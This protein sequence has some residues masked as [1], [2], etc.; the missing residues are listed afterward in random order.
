[1]KYFYLA[2]FMLAMLFVGCKD[3]SPPVEQTTFCTD[4]KPTVQSQVDS[5]LELV[6]TP[7]GMSLADIHILDSTGAQ[8][9]PADVLATI[10]S[11]AAENAVN[12]EFKTQVKAEAARQERPTN[13][14]PDV[15]KLLYSLLGA[16]LFLLSQ[17]LFRGR[18]LFANTD[19]DHIR[20]I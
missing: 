6:I 1:M 3:P 8:L 20:G 2:A 15:G 18:S 17:S 9:Q 12:A 14:L 19:D 10:A 11:D 5:A 13:L 4:F 16:G 7:Y